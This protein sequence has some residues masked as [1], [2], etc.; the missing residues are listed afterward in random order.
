MR[1]NFITINKLRLAQKLFNIPRNVGASE[2]LVEITCRGGGNPIVLIS[3][4]QNAC[5]FV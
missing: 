1:T 5:F 3:R 4:Q 2:L